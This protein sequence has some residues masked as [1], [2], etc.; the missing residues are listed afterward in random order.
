MTTHINTYTHIQYTCTHTH[1]PANTLDPPFCV[2][3]CRP[4]TGHIS[5]QSPNKRSQV[6]PISLNE[7]QQ[8]P[9]V[10]TGP[11]SVAYALLA[12]MKY[13]SPTYC[14]HSPVS[15]LYGPTSPLKEPFKGNRGFLSERHTESPDPE[16]GV[17]R[18]ARGLVE[19]HGGL[20]VRHRL[21]QGGAGIGG[22]FK[23]S[24]RLL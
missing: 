10:S 6:F 22:P 23:R 2:R 19:L 24:Y 12:Y 16:D 15:A 4:S 13:Q 20:E 5:H 1:I 9:I 7:A 18:R 17:R 8:P 14:Q 3:T 21:R 11:Y